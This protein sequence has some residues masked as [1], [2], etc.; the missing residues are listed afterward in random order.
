METTASI[1]VPTGKDILSALVSSSAAWIDRSAEG[2]KVVEHILSSTARI[3]VFSGRAGCGKTELFERSVL[4]ALPGDRNVF[5]SHCF[6]LPPT[7]RKIGDGEAE[8]WSTTTSPGIIVLDQFEGFFG[9]DESVRLSFM[10]QLSERLSTG[11][12]E[13]VLVLVLAEENLSD[14]LSLREHLPQVLDDLTKIGAVPAEKLR[15][16]LRGLGAERDLQID[17]AVLKKLV[18]DLRKPEASKYGVSPELL[19]ALVFEMW[20]SNSLLEKQAF[21][22]DEYAAAGEI[23][24]MLENYLEYRLDTVEDEFVRRLTGAVLK[25]V[26]FTARAGNAPDF[27]DVGRRYDASKTQV[28]NV[29]GSLLDQN[30]KI[31]RETESS[32]YEVVPAQLTLV[33]DERI[34]RDRQRNQPAQ[35]LLRQ[36]V[37][38]F[39]ERGVPLSEQEFSKLHRQR[40][41]LRVTEE[42]ARLMLGCA[43][44]YEDPHLEAAVQHWLRRAGDETTKVEIL[45]GGVF[46]PRDAVRERA[47]AL[48]GG[49][50][51]PEV[52]NQLYLLALKDPKDAVRDRAIE[53][54]S[55]LK[56]EPL[57]Q[58]LFKEIRDPNSQNP[59]NAVSAL[60]IFPDK[61]TADYLGNLVTKESP[62][63]IR[64]KAIQVLG[65]LRIPEAI[66]V[67]LRVAI[68][69][70]DEGDRG[71]AAEVLGSRRGASLS[72]L[73]EKLQDESRLLQQARGSL[74]QSTLVVRLGAFALAA[75]VIF[76]NLF[77][78]G[79]ILC[80]FRR[81]KLG[82]GFFAVEALTIALITYDA[83][84]SNGEM[85]WAGVTVCFLAMAASQLAATWIVLQEKEPA[86]GTRSSYIASLRLGLFLANAV[87][88]FLVIHGL[89]HIFIRR[90][91]RGV[92]LFTYEVVGSVLLV[93]AFLFDRLG[94]QRLYRFYLVAGIALF[95]YSYLVDVVKV[96]LHAVVF[97]RK[98]EFRQRIAAVC[99]EVMKNPE[100]CQILL[101]SLQ[102]NQTK[103]IQ[104]VSRILTTFTVESQPLVAPVKELWRDAD[105][106]TRRRMT[107]VLAVHRD[108]LSVKT[109]RELT[110]QAGWAG[111]LTCLWCYVRYRVLPTALLRVAVLGVLVLVGSLSVYEVTLGPKLRVINKAKLLKDRHK[112]R[113]ERAR[114]AMELA[115]ADAK[116]AFD[117]VKEVLDR[118]DEEPAVKMQ[119]LPSLAQIAGNRSSDYP[120]QAEEVLADLARDRRVLIDLRKETLQQLKSIALASQ[121]PE[122]RDESTSVLYDL[123]KSNE[124]DRSL[125]EI[126]VVAFKEIGTPRACDT[127]RAF[128]MLRPAQEGLRAG[129]NAKAPRGASS[130]TTLDE[131]ER[132]LRQQAIAALTQLSQES[133]Q[134]QSSRD[135]YYAFQVLQSLAENSD[136]HFDPRLRNAAQKQ[137][138]SI[139]PV[140]MAQ[141]ALNQSKYRSAIEKANAIVR[142]ESDPSR[143][144]KALGILQDSY[145]GLIQPPYPH[146]LW[147]EI[148]KNLKDVEGLNKQ[149]CYALATAYYNIDVPQRRLEEA[150]AEL[151][152]LQQRCPDSI[153]P[154]LNLAAVYHD[155][156]APTDASF[157]AKAYE[158]LSPLLLRATSE[159]E[160]ISAQANLAESSLTVGLYD[161]THGLGNEILKSQVL[162]HNKA[163]QLSVRFLIFA[164]LVFQNDT[165]GSDRQLKDLL[166]LYS[167]LPEGFYNDWDF[168][169]T[170]NYV[171]KSKLS[172]DQRALLLSTIDLIAGTKSQQKLDH[173]RA[174]APGP[175]RTQ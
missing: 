8:F 62:C 104:R 129:K 118:N 155:E 81:L 124:E 7:L 88:F 78:S 50:N 170:R 72:D 37:R 20:R 79:L 28:L 109:V 53:S 167:S 139:D 128:V 11:K 51:R 35:S 48:L 90:F 105:T 112:E 113:A 33:I 3:I 29:L 147:D 71:R 25:E 102:G 93:Y 75:L 153:Q 73:L 9:E 106:V 98:Y 39:R 87:S 43:L 122:L 110:V 5:Y 19:G 40:S 84:Y 151:A 41:S 103:V 60:R 76:L 172:A 163:L 6:K 65:D 126:A 30:P 171:S 91:A 55:A 165:Q 156:L 101:R 94:H 57:R 61:I 127:L 132:E 149:G 95:A 141:F 23:S 66:D 46:D 142:S 131:T 114:A 67:L 119:I 22:L 38:V 159:D 80:T 100:A 1:S 44:V 130:D 4:P 13:A 10:R 27:D 97:K 99:R 160:R 86:G 107:S 168:R 31:L 173:F 174:R 164:S 85:G 175:T 143:S 157:Y 166:T 152:S 108:E 36:A 82:L 146:D 145:Y 70:E 63:P 92:K 135:A 18:D 136:K 2:R 120:R 115:G 169:G 161:Q 16:A 96:F 69:D 54:L 148:V 32:R 24:G 138:A 14:L 21:G 34:E 52:Q 154:G 89:A 42:E 45:L 144:R 150:A 111:R 137:L 117:G 64:E 74:E 17:D 140:A 158:D 58:S 134:L 56:D 68:Q 26:V 59:G 162:S 49:F 83:K 77:F 125:R 123:L 15:S 116:E 12:F 121:V 47:A 133:A